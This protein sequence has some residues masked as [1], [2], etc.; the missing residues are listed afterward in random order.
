LVRFGGVV[1][2]DVQD[3]LDPGAVQ[4]LDHVPKLVDRAERIPT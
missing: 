2:H 4:G 3:H 1:V